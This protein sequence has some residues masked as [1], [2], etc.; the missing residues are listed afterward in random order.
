M[1]KLTLQNLREKDTETLGKRLADVLFDGAFV[2]LYGDLGAGKTT[3]VRSVAAG[4][5]IEGIIS[6]T[7]T[8]VREYEGKLPLAHFDAYRLKSAQELYD[9]G[10]D[11]Y[12]SR[13][14]VILMEWSENVLDALPDDRL[15][16]RIFGDGDMPRNIEIESTG[17]LHS[18]IVEALR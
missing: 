15:E 3:L 7:F 17:K 12:L 11:D 8:I 6:P 13:G 10:F 2:A 4:L 1:P 18:T 16:I 9:I 5:G 14:G